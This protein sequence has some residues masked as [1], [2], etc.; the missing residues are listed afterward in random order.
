MAQ[1]VSILLACRAA[2][3]FGRTWDA[4]VTDYSRSLRAIRKA[5]PAR[6]EAVKT[7]LALVQNVRLAEL[8][9]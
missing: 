3:A 5:F 4:R 6:A 8:C 9:S 2:A 1:V 7:S